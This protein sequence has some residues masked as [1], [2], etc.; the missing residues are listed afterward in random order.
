VT[1][2]LSTP[3]ESLNDVSEAARNLED[4][5]ASAVLAWT[6]DQFDRVALVASFQAESVVLIDLA[7]R[8]RD[9]VE[10]IT[11]DTGRLPQETYDLIETV[12]R[13]FPIRLHVITPA[14]DELSAITS[15][16]GVNLFYRSVEA[17]HLCC[18]VRK[19]RPLRRALAGYDAWVTGL[20]REQSTARAGVPVVARDPAH[21]GIAKVA[22]LATW[23]REQV[24][25]YVEAYKLPHHALYDRGYTSIG[26]APCTRASRPGEGERAGRW[27]W[28]TN[29][30]KECGLHGGVP[31]PAAAVPTFSLSGEQG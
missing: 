17:R 4:E 5:T 20:R 25:S 21:G 14:S 15:R 19:G 24:W 30:L 10:V 26:C 12:R 22:P 7:C 11:L 18:E 2:P 13:R 1:H 3:R 31:L 29:S 8:L 6:F 27:W 9:C 28:E 16:H 23:T